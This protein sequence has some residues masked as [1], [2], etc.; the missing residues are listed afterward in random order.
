MRKFP[1]IVAALTSACCVLL[2]AGALFPIAS[3]LL[4]GLRDASISPASAAPV[5][6]ALGAIDGLSRRPKNRMLV[7]AKQEGLRRHAFQ[8]SFGR[9]PPTGYGSDVL[10]VTRDRANSGDAPSTMI[11][12]FPGSFAGAALT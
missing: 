7:L 11:V 5:L 4:A 12:F 1:W 3:D 9:V 10:A 8:R 2:L 6:A